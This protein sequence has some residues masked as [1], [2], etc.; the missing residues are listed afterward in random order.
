MKYFF[1]KKRIPEPEQEMEGVDEARTYFKGN[2]RN[3]KNG[4]G[5][6]R[7]ACE[8]LRL[9]KKKEEKVL[10]VGCAFGGVMERL[11]YR[12]PNLEVIGVDLS[13]SLIKLGKKYVGSKKSVFKKMSADNLRFKDDTFDA[14][15]CKDTFHHFKNPVKVLKEM[16]R[17]LKK[18]GYVYLI[19]L[20]RNGDQDA[21]YK[22]LQKIAESSSIY[23]TQ[24][25]H[26]MRAAYTIKEMINL[27]KKAGLK[28]YKFWKPNVEEEFSKEKDFDL[29]R[30]LDFEI[31]LL[32]RWKGVIKK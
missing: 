15:V 22:L 13:K 21:Y 16:F 6:D 27:A 8:L 23:G 14:V 2:T 32:N 25:I 9:M 10:D 18:G 4:S 28:K 3:N 26:S 24:F 12:A 1:L 7:V 29:S 17:V 5:Y 31:N 30:F 19:D 11:N 20:R